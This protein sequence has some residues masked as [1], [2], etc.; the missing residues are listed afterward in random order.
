MRQYLPKNEAAAIKAKLESLEEE[1]MELHTAMEEW[2]DERSEA[3]QDSE[4]GED[5]QE[6]ME[7]LDYAADGF[8][9]I[10]DN[11]DSFIDE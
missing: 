3:W 4:K 8:Q 7:Y 5:Y 11:L 1:I 10:I 6:K 9:D 2:Y